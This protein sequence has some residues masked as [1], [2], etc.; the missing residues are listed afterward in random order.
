MQ[1]VLGLVTIISQAFTH[2]HFIHFFMLS[3]LTRF[4]IESRYAVMTVT[5]YFQFAMVFIPMEISIVVEIYF[6]VRM[7]SLARVLSGSVHIGLEVTLWPT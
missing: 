2:I 6:M 7:I 3:I 1:K 4:S 5:V